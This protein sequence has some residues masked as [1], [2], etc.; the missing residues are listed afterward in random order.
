LG[1]VTIQEISDLRQ[2]GIDVYIWVVN[3]PEAMKRLIVAG[4]SGLFTDYPQVLKE[5]L[6]QRH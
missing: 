4:A 3:E 2:K 6:D 1:E 5:I